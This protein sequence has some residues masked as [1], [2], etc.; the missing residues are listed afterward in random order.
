M[1][2]L[3]ITFSAYIEFLVV[4]H[5]EALDELLLVLG[6]HLVELQVGHDVVVGAD[7]LEVVVDDALLQVDFVHGEAP[8]PVEHQ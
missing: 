5:V 1:E 8:G 6:G 4:V 7:V 3:D 2:V